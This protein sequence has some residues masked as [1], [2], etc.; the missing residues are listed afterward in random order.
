MLIRIPRV[1]CTTV[2]GFS[3]RQGTCSVLLRGIVARPKHPKCPLPPAQRLCVRCGVTVGRPSLGSV[4]PTAIQTYGIPSSYGVSLV[5]WTH[6]CRLT[7]ISALLMLN[8]RLG[9]TLSLVAI[10]AFLRSTLEYVVHV[11][12]DAFPRI[13]TKVEN[14]SV[15]WEKCLPCH[16]TGCYYIKLGLV[17]NLEVY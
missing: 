13:R 6:S 10:L 17:I 4:Y 14:S 7:V 11:Y 2:Y 9:W 5:V 15:R 1:C 3:L 12:L 16:L 8:C